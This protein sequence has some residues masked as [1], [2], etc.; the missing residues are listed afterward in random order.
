M[1]HVITDECISC[2]VCVD[3]CAVEAISEGE[4]KYVIDPEKMHGL[5]LLCR[6]MSHRSYKRRRRIGIP[7]QRPREQTGS[8][9]WFHV[10]QA[11]PVPE[12]FFT[13][14]KSLLARKF[15]RRGRFAAPSTAARGTP[16]AAAPH[17][18]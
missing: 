16:A 4:D 7:N 6:G 10:K 8:L 14:G 9:V 12:G 2:G 13:P 15:S 11:H 17:T 18:G 5:R 1:A 3:E